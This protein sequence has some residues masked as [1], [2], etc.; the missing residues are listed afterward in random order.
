MAE[1]HGQAC[2]DEGGL[3]DL[4]I[5]PSVG[6]LAKGLE[7]YGDTTSLVA[8]SKPVLDNGFLGR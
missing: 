5:S 3:P 4:V 1:L 2:V 6:W 8:V 7:N